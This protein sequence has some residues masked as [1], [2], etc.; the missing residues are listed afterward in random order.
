MRI[1]RPLILLLALLLR[2][3]FA[4]F[5]QTFTTVPNWLTAA[6]GTEPVVLSFSYI[7]AG[8]YELASVGDI[9]VRWSGQILPVRLTSPT[10]LE[11]TVPA[12]LRL[13][14][15]TEFVLW[16]AK[17][18]QPLP[19]RG[20]ISVIIPNPASMF[21]TDPAS[22]R[23][24]AANAGQITV[25]SLAT[26]VAT[27]TVALA[28][29]ERVLA[30]TPDTAYAWI[31][32]DEV[33]GT[34]ARLN[35]TT[36]QLD[37]Q[38]QVTG[39]SAPYTLSAQVYRQDP[40][41]LIVTASAGVFNATRAYSSGTLLP[42]A[43]PAST[44]VPLESDDRGRLLTPHGQA[45]ELTAVSGFT[46]CVTVNAALAYGYTPI[47]ALWKNKALD[48]GGRILDV[49]TGN[50]IFTLQYYP[51]S[52]LY[53]A[54]SNRLLL[55]S[56][57]LA[58]ADA[59]SL[60]TYA[61]VGSILPYMQD[62]PRRI[63]APDW[64]LASTVS[65]VPVT[66]ENVRGILVGHL[67]Q[68]APAPS[69]SASGLLNAATLKAAQLSPGEI[70]SIF[71][72]NLG[73]ASGA[74][75]VLSGAAHLATQVEQLQVLFDGIPGAILYAG[76]GQINVVVPETVRPSGSVA[77]QVVHYGLPS[78]RISSAT[79]TASPGIF[80]YA[81]Q[82]KTYAA[83]LNPDGAMQGPTAPLRRGSTTAF[84]TTGLGLP[85]NVTADAIAVRAAEVPARPSVTIGGRPAQV[86]YAGPSPGL[87]A[88]LAQLNV[89]IPPDAP[90]GS[91]VEVVLSSGNLTA[92][93]V[94]VAIQ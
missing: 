57:I 29:P 46:N 85:A 43:A 1:Y 16:D 94:W 74:G 73:P 80:G 56:N 60:E 63:W 23:V 89:V 47:A 2:C 62:P 58:A 50:T 22:D 26:G 66:G 14:G 11:F 32:Q 84:Y 65:S 30:F 81:A 39:G 70:V 92:G 76:A 67:P 24:V 9:G 6:S 4:A 42:N 33:Q 72:Q 69:F 75:P 40:R 3:P 18:Q 59:D 45:C 48:P 71:G 83:A 19:F 20:W 10:K 38:F 77:V 44:F 91:A 37:Q 27:Q 52:A 49:T 82:G 93:N 12:A 7:P 79:A 35:I 41:I 17:S 51:A 61:D 15:I 28:S 54:S 87:T 53:L 55:R 21:E 13:P 5:S 25:Y 90:T 64:I 31:A 8:T 78:A 86:T 88:G 34:I 36:G 68:L